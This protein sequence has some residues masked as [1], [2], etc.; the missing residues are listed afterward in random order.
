M[1][2]Y[3]ITTLKQSALSLAM[4]KILDIFKKWENAHILE[5]PI[6]KLL[7]LLYFMEF[8]VVA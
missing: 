6:F 4:A 2:K 1:Q 7:K 8:F 3:Y 5:L